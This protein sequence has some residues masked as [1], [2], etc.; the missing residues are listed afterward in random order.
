MMRS[1]FLSLLVAASCLALSTPGLASPV[2]CPDEGVQ[3]QQVLLIYDR[4]FIGLWEV[5]GREPRE[6]KL[7][8]GFRLGVAISPAPR[9]IYLRADEW[10]GEFMHE[11]VTIQLFDMGSSPP[12]QLYKT[13]GGSSS[14]Q[15]YG[16]MGSATKEVELFLQ[17]PVCVRVADVPSDDAAGVE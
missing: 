6:I 8:T 13:Y 4:E 9:E 1:S 7:P 2:T 12:K 14:L 17:R 15:V 3:A 10:A 5:T 11:L 16:P